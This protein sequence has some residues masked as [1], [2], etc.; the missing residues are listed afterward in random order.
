MLADAF[1]SEGFR[2]RIA[3]VGDFVEVVVLEGVAFD[4]AVVED[5]L[6][7]G[8]DVFVVDCV[9]EVVDDGDLV[10][11][12]DDDVSAG[13]VI[14]RCGQVSSMKAGLRR[15]MFMFSLEVMPRFDVNLT[16]KNGPDREMTGKGP[17]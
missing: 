6:L 10:V 11:V 1:L 2:G 4:V 12:A 15:A 8:D 3:V 16:V 14:G 9:A 13:G 7:S 5:E 17:S